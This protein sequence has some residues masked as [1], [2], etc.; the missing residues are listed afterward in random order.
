MFDQITGVG[1]AAS[2]EARAAQQ[3]SVGDI[4][5]ALLRTQ[6]PPGLEDD[7]EPELQMRNL[8]DTLP[9]QPAA[10]LAVELPAF[11]LPQEVLDDLAASATPDELAYRSSEEAGFGQG[12][13]AGPG[14]GSGGGSGG[15]GS[16]AARELLRSTGLVSGAVGRRPSALDRTLVDEA[17]PA[18]DMLLQVPLAGPEIDFASLA[19]RGTTQID[20]PEH[21]DEDFDYSV[22]TYRDPRAGGEAGYFRVDVTARRSLHKLRAMPKDVIF[23]VDTSSSLPQ[24][25]INEVSL[26]V[27]QAIRVLNEGDRFN[28]VLFKENPAFF[29]TRGPRPVT[30]ENVE[31]AQ[32]FITTARSE[33]YTDVNAALSQLLVRDVAQ[34]RVY[35]LILISDGMP[36]KGVVD[37]REL[38]NLIT[39]DND[40]TASI[41]CV[42]IGHRQ[43]RE[44]LDFL[45][46]RNKGY[47]LYATRTQDVAPTL[48][49]LASRLRYPL[50][51]DLRVSVAGRGIH[52]VYPLHLPNIHQGERFSLFGRYGQPIE[53]TMQI[54]GRSAGGG[55][56]DF[57]FTR[58]LAR[59][60][61]GEAR[62]AGDW[63][64]WKLHHL[65][66]ELIRRGQDGEILNQIEVLRRRYKLKTLY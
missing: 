22:T 54:A 3:M 52:D 40:L 14:A 25:W 6:E 66:S 50:I 62:I 45:S 20:V 59:A 43:N 5:Q 30:V 39:R 47:S 63:A 11:E 16:A 15:G 41:Y 26:G 23:L 35:E 34:D 65:Y 42:G 4:T 29:S 24:S 55:N 17:A 28:V 58:D 27:G 2:A 31:A 12:D 61:A 53:F 37:T 51:K 44:L 46:Y 10:E 64:F 21:L 49:D 7:F 48:R 19:L 13:A 18:E 38:I 9:A 36:T 33:G 1:S 56:V 32:T 8:A 60:P 57:T